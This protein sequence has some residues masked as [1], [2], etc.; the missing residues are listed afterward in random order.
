[1]GFVRLSALLRRYVDDSHNKLCPAC[2]PIRF[3]TRLSHG[4]STPRAGRF[5]FMSKTKKQD[6]GPI[7]LLQVVWEH[8]NEGKSHSWRILNGMLHRALNIA[9]N[10]G[11]KFEPDDFETI[12]KRFSGHYWMGDSIPPFRGEGFYTEA[13][14]G[15]G[16]YRDCYCQHNRSACIS[17][18]KWVGRKPFILDGKRLCVGSRIEIE[19]KFYYVSSFAKDNAHLNVCGY[20]SQENP[21]GHQQGTPTKRFK[22]AHADVKAVEKGEFKL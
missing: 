15:D 22:L 4:V 7:K 3:G 9:I 17:F 10:S 8:A 5:F 14:A 6:S 16:G 19:G 2:G 1:M 11:F 12:H 13:V 18:E 20:H 21:Y